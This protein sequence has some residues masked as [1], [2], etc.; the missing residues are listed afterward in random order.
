MNNTRKKNVGN[1]I[2]KLR[3]QMGYTQEQLALQCGTV[4]QRIG[5]F[6]RGATLPNTEMVIKLSIA[7]GCTTDYLPKGVK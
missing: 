6:E 2:K 3:K 5:E 1:I 4:Y 7:L